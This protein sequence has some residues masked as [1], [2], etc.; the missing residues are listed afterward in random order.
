[1]Q[2]LREYDGENNRWWV[3]LADNAIC[4]RDYAG[5]ICGNRDGRVYDGL[6]CVTGVICLNRYM[7]VLNVE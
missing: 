3:K 2:G 1:M 6:L 5:G 4:L 7:V